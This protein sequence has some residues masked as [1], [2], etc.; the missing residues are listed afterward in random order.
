[1]SH[2]T[3]ADEE[4]EATLQSG[5]F[6][7]V[8][9]TLGLILGPIL[10]LGLAV[11]GGPDALPREAW[12]TLCVLSLMLVWWFTEAVP[13]AATALIPLVAFPLFG[14]TDAEGA[15]TPYADPIVFLF[16]GGFMIARCIE[17][18]NLHARIA[19]QVASRIGANPAALIG[20]FILAAGLISLWISNTATALMLTPIAVGVIKAMAEHGYEDATFSA[21]L[22]LGVAYAASVGGMGTPVGSP[23]NL[24]A[25]GFLNAREIELSFAQWMLLGVPVVIL[26]LPTLW[27]LVTRGLKRATADDAARGREVLNAA[28]A[29][30]GPMRAPERRVLVVFA[31]VAAAWMLREL[32]IL[33]PPF[34]HLSDMSIAIAGALALFLLPAGIS[35]RSARLL[36]WRTA[37]RI[38]WG[39][40]LLYGGGL[41]VAAAMESTGLSVWLG[42]ALQGLRGLDLLLIVGVLLGVTLITTE[43]MSNVA[44]LTAMLPIVAALAQALDVNPLLLV[45]PVSIAASLG[46]MLPIAT[47]PNAI[48]YATGYAELQRM[49]RVGFAL[50]LIGIAAILI[51]NATLARMVLS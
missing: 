42:E 43:L 28:L 51:V 15:A 50:N 14:V 8:G 13:I 30:L 11:L 19:L 7:R 48:A 36:D 16:I 45:F 24:I 20:G 29:E 41:S 2:R 38:P 40:V 47:A 10:A 31:V 46:F 6:G 22:V 37:E 35:G 12:I 25:M 18:W 39:I 5:G 17:R 9:R 1:V 49:L 34:A 32:L 23:T 3:T 27:F 44:T 26:M 21:G 33:L 4:A